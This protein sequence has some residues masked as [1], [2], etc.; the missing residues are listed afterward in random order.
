VAQRLA[1]GR[2]TVEDEQRS[3][4][5][6]SVR[7]RTNVD[8]VGAFIRQ[9]RR[10]MMRIIADEININECTVHQVVTRDLNMRTVCAKMVP[11]NLN[12]DQKAHRNEVSAEMLQRL[13]TEPDFVNGVVTGDESWFLE[14]GPETRRQ[15]GE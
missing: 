11:E 12:D 4:R 8:R 7:T 3:G 13:E 1:N 10:L 2:E 15:S 6:A 14:Y 9:D 5:P